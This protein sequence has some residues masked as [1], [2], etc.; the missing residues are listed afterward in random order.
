MTFS[1]LRPKL[2]LDRVALAH[3]RKDAERQLDW[4]FIRVVNA[5]YPVFQSVWT[6]IIVCFMSEKA[7]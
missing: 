4:G 3:L 6:E 5:N 1:Q 2:R 7:E